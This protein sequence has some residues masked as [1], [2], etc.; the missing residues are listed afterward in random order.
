[1][2]KKHITITDLSSALDASSITQGIYVWKENGYVVMGQSIVRISLTDRGNDS[3]K[4]IFE[5]VVH[6]AQFL[7]ERAKQYVY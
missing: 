1:M 7:R 3:T 4:Q 5:K 2:I 6:T